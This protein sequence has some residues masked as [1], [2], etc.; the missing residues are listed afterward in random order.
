[1]GVSCSKSNFAS[2]PPFSLELIFH[3]VVCEISLLLL[4]HELTKAAIAMTIILDKVEDRMYDVGGTAVDATK[5]VLNKEYRN[6]VGMDS[7]SQAMKRAKKI[8][9]NLFR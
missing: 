7:Q 8:M 9:G 2:N 6:L 1:M 3:P 5:Y 4:L